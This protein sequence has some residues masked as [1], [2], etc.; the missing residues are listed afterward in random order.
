MKRYLL[1]YFCLLCGCRSYAYTYD[2]I[3]D[4]I[5]TIQCNNIPEIFCCQVN[6]YDKIRRY[7]GLKKLIFKDINENDTLV[8]AELYSDFYNLNYSLKWRNDMLDLISY[9][10]SNIDKNRDIKVL[11]NEG[12]PL[13]SLEL[14][15]NLQMGKTEE[16]DA[17][18]QKKEKTLHSESYHLSFTKIILNNNS[19]NIY[20]IWIHI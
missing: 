6:K 1:V 20:H 9:T 15:N 4:S 8:I 5:Y 18:V 13:I 11:I 7:E 14:L 19:F 2:D 10:L 12:E 17:Y 3:L 16:I